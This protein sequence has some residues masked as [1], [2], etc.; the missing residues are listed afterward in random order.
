MI[1][2]NPTR[3]LAWCAKGPVSFGD[4]MTSVQTPEKPCLGGLASL[5]GPQ[6]Q[7]AC[8]RCVASLPNCDVALDST[9]L[10]A[11][12]VGAMLHSLG[13]T[14]V[15]AAARISSVGNAQSMGIELHRSVGQFARS[16][17]SPRMSPATWICRP[18]TILPQTRQKRLSSRERH[19]RN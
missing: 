8:F 16:S 9:P 2:Q 3:F 12:L 10:S 11:A 14:V 18:V 17:P 7:K 1:G 13:A 4:G 6:A 19:S 15:S 5:G